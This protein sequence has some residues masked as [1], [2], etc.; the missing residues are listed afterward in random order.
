MLEL[1]SGADDFPRLYKC[2]LLHSPNKPFRDTITLFFT[3]PPDHDFVHL[4][5]STNSDEGCGEL[6]AGH[7]L[8]LGPRSLPKMSDVAIDRGIT[9]SLFVS[10]LLVLFA[11]VEGCGSH[12]S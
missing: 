12:R 9:L 8:V 3:P 1:P 10:S 4:K 6:S 5:Y 7:A 11:F 2:M